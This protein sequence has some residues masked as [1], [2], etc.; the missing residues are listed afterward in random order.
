MKKFISEKDKLEKKSTDAFDSLFV[1]KKVGDNIT[2]PEVDEGLS[3]RVKSREGKKA[4]LK[5]KKEPVKRYSTFGEN[6]KTPV[7]IEEEIVESVE[8][9]PTEIDLPEESFDNN[10]PMQNYI[11]VMRKN[12]E[13]TSDLTE[14]ADFMAGGRDAPVTRGDLQKAISVSLSSLGGGGMGPN[15]VND[16]VTFGI[17][18]LDSQ[19]Q[20]TFNN[21]TS[22][23]VQEGENNLYYTSARHDSDTLAMV[24]SDY[25]TERVRINTNLRFKGDLFVDV[26]DAPTSPTDGD[27][28]I[29]DSDAV[30]GPTWTGIVGETVLQAQAVAWSEDN[31]RWYAMGGIFEVDEVGI[32]EQATPVGSMMMW[33]GSTDPDGWFIL[34]GSSFDTTDNPKLHAYLTSN[35]PD[36]SSGTLPDYRGHFPGGH[37]ALGM[38]SDMGGKT[39]ATTGDPGVSV[40]SNGSHKHTATTTATTT[41]TVGGGGTVNTNEA[42]SHRHKFG[43]AAVVGGNNSDGRMYH[44]PENGTAQTGYAG[45]HSHTVDLSNISASGT[46]TA[47]TSLENAGSHSHSLSGWDTRTMPNAFAI[48]FMIKHD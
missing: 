45:T 26:G 3:E 25:V 22:D 48:N 15:D 42:G 11:E 13:K 12:N 24:D 40:V 27:M 47:T 30:A 17:G 39:S 14:A 21:L 38:S 19:I 18:Q 28:Y 37:G 23:S 7:V 36:Y 16:I 41:V 1:E 10:D 46:T 5:E 33:M 35:F 32:V 8:F 31:S 29:N 4:L 44:D 2:I 6:K 9:S 43:N 20:D 34:N